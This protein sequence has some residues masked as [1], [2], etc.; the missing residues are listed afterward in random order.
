MEQE[1]TF[2]HYKKPFSYEVTT[3]IECIYW[4]NKIVEQIPRGDE[5]DKEIKTI[6]EL[7]SNNI[8][9]SMS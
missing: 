9:E 3:T 6:L 1:G 7:Y 2:G 5:R 8:A 4:V